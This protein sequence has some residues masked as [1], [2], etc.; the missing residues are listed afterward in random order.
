MARHVGPSVLSVKT[1][2]RSWG[3]EE[4]PPARDEVS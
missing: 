2:V 1:A 4:F 3:A